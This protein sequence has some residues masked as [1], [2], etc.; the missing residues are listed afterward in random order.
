M[1]SFRLTNWMN[2]FPDGTSTTT[3]MRIG[4]ILRVKG[5]RV[6]VRLAELTQ[7]AFEAAL[8]EVEKTTYRVPFV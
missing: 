5:A 3:Y 1:K 2:Y 4:R 7:E 6:R 8:K